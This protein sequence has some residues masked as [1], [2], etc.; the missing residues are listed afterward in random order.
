MF[1]AKIIKI[2]ATFF[3]LAI[4]QPTKKML[5]LSNYLSK[6]LKTPHL[7]FFGEN[8]FKIFTKMIQHLSL[9]FTFGLKVTGEDQSWKN[10]F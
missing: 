1:G 6:S 10:C 7:P 2:E 9:F 5:C 4:T 3:D 8:L